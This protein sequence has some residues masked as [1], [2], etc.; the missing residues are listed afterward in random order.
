MT[1]LFLVLL[2]PLLS[3]PLTSTQT[4]YYVRPT[5]ESPCHHEDCLT[6]SEYASETSR[7]FNSDNLILVFRPGEHALNTSIEFQLIKHLTLLGDI[8]S[9]PSITSK[10]VCNETSAFALIDISSVEIKALAFRSCGSLH[11]SDTISQSLSEALNVAENVAPVISVLFIQNFHLVSCHMECNYLPLRLNNSRAHL[12]DNQFVS[13]NGSLGGAIAAYNSTVAF[14]GQNLFLGNDAVVGGA[15]FADRS[16][17]VLRESTAFIDNTAEYGGGIGADNSTLLYGDLS[18]NSSS[19]NRTHSSTIFIQNLAQ[20]DGGGISLVNSFMWLK[21]GTLNFTMNHAGSEG[22]GIISDSSLIRLDGFV[23]FERNSANVS[24]GGFTAR[25]YSTWNSSVVTFVGNTA[26]FGGA[27]ASLYSH[28]TFSAL[29]HTGAHNTGSGQESVSC[30]FMKHL[31]QNTFRNNSASLGGALYVKRNTIVF[32]GNTIFEQ[33]SLSPSLFSEHSTILFKRPTTF[34]NNSDGGVLIF[35]S[36]LNFEEHTIF[37]G[38]YAIRGGGIQATNS[39]LILSG[40]VGFVSNE[41]QYYDGGG[42]YLQNCTLVLNGTGSYFNNTA[43]ENGGVISAIQGSNVVLDGENTM[44]WNSATESGGAVSVVDST[45]TITG[46]SNFVENWADYSGGALYAESSNL[47]LGSFNNFVSN[48][49]TGAAINLATGGHGYGGAL[50]VV[51]TL[52]TLSGIHRLTNNSAI[53]GGGLAITSYDTE[54]F[55]YLT[56]NAAVS[57]LDNYAQKRGGAL[58]VDDAQDHYCGPDVRALSKPCFIEFDKVFFTHKFYWLPF[59][60]HCRETDKY[61]TQCLGHIFFEDNF[62]NEG[63][64]TIYGGNLHS[65]KVRLTTEQSCKIEQNCYISGLEAVAALAQVSVEQLTRDPLNVESYTYKV[66]TC[67]SH[68]PNCKQRTI[69]HTAYPGETVSIP[70]VAVG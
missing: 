57:F 3:L 34:I 48:V 19:C 35:E 64:D 7:Y 39:T 54:H 23:I 53:Y 21:G 25:S 68:K 18:N 14:L 27:F 70:L 44:I 38:N 63:G 17:L 65:C 47:T 22:G 37:T 13:N 66:C 42:V 51:T 43:G 9:F 32:N 30:P 56:P 67:D 49:A 15:V 50:H 20:S 5:L 36:Q 29:V 28:L 33:N 58:F 16:E 52:L 62:A 60:D 45:L 40:K 59:V 10:I 61:I 4:T 2:F 41:A 11:K 24:G 8:S 6:L 1:A 12:T 46:V 69:N 26:L 55:L 31:Y